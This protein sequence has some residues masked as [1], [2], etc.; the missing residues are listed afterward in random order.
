M[1]VAFVGLEIVVDHT[2]LLQAGVLLHLTSECERYVFGCY[3]RFT[4]IYSYYVGS[5]YVHFLAVGI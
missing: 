5:S 1:G 4:Y 2:S 3:S